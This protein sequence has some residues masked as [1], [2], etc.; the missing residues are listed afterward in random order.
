MTT[1]S[2][3]EIKNHENYELGKN[4]STD[5]SMVLY[6]NMDGYPLTS[7]NGVVF[8]I[9]KVF[10]KTLDQ[11]P[12]LSIYTPP[13]VASLIIATSYNNY[14]SS[15]K[16][17]PTLYKKIGTLKT[18]CEYLYFIELDEKDWFLKINHDGEKRK[19]SE[20]VCI[21]EIIKE[22]NINRYNM[23]TKRMRI[24]EKLY[25]KS[26]CIECIVKPV[27][28]DIF[29]FMGYIINKPCQNIIDLT[30]EYVFEVKKTIPND[31]LKYI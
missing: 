5:E 15:C 25:K 26:P 2:L 4:I 29:P 23:M 14:H 22:Y 6:V 10:K 27:C 9:C 11:Q 20:W 17:L 24:T 19:L 18:N 31:L 30:Y 7:L 16:V 21:S 28:V 8:L 12:Y 3:I 13:N 1:T